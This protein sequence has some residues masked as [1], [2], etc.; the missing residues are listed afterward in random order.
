MNSELHTQ[1]VQ[2]V[3]EIGQRLK[4]NP[5]EGFELTEE[6]RA[7]LEFLPPEIIEQHQITHGRYSSLNPDF[8]FR[9][10]AWTKYMAYLMLH[11]DDL[12]E[13]F[14]T[15]FEAGKYT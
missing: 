7:A 9:D 3:A 8:D 6:E 5:P 12:R 2:A 1:Y 11:I 15:G 13:A 10:A 4:D 14:K